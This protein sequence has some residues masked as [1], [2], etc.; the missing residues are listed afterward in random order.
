M[1]SV[2][3]FT[4]ITSPFINDNIDVQIYAVNYHKAFEILILL[5]PNYSTRDMRYDCRVLSAS[6]LGWI[7]TAK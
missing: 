1:F 4:I 7:G 3:L 6:P 2:Y 5:H